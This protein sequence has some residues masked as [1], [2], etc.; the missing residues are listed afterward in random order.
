MEIMKYK[1]IYNKE[2]QKKKFKH[3][4]ALIQTDYYNKI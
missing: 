2:W 1:N 3:T 4:M